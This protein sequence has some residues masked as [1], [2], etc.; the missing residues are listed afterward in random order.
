MSIRTQR[1][2]SVIKQDLSKILLDYQHNNIIT[3]T[4]VKMTPDLSIARVY[5]SVIDSSGADE[6]VYQ[7]LSDK[8]TAIRA[9]LSALL[10]HQL[11]K[12]PEIE[13]YRDETAEYASKM[14][15]LFRKV[16]DIPPAPPEDDKK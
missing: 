6:T 12:M 14:E 13:F 5:I 8:K 4:D 7:M 16:K 1:V 15:N 11:R 2:A 3:I 10:R 9:A